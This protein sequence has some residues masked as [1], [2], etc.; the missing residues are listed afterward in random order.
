MIKI[1]VIGKSGNA[2]RHINVIKELNN[3]HLHKVL[4]YKKCFKS[5]L[6]LTTDIEELKDSE[7]IIISSP[8]DTHFSYLKLLINLTQRLQVYE[9]L[10]KSYAFSTIALV[11]NEAIVSTKMELCGKELDNEVTSKKNQITDLLLAD[12]FSNLV[13]SAL[14]VKYYSKTTTLSKL[15]QKGSS[16][17]ELLNI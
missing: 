15:E 2:S 14:E 6:P 3:V 16:K 8:T 4:Y 10:H 11:T 5:N 12:M 7:G 1:S 13:C 9:I 17:L